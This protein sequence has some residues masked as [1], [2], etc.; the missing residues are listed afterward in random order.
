MKRK[1][2]LTSGLA[3]MLFAFAGCA[4]QPVA[5]NPVVT[6][7]YQLVIEKHPAMKSAQDNIKAEYEKIR[8]DVKDTEGLEP[9]EKQKKIMELQKHLDEFGKAQTEPIKESVDTSIDSVMK[10]KGAKVVV[11]KQAVLR[12][13]V[14]I[15]KDVLIKEGLSAEEA[16]KLID[17]NK[18]EE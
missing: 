11:V 7:D 14:D 12:G 4:N 10:E 8:N 1:I 3:V 6:V 5:E 18:K 9:Q 15:T 13:G 17:E 2:I 16:Q